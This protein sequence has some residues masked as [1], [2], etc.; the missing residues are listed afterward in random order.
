M[1]VVAD[2]LDRLDLKAGLRQAA[3]DLKGVIRLGDGGV[4]P[5]PGNWHSHRQISIPNALLNRTS[6]S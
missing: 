3:A 5:Q 4:L 6:P 2:L 1:H